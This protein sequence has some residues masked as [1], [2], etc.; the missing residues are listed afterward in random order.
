MVQYLPSV[1]STAADTDPSR[2]SSTCRR[3]LTRA[4]S[5]RRQVE[6]VRRTLARVVLAE[7][8]RTPLDEPDSARA[9]P[10]GSMREPDTDLGETLPQVAFFART[11]LP[12][13]LKDLMRS[14]GPALSYQPPGYG[15][16]LRR[17]QRLFRNRLDADRSV[18]QRSAK[19]ITR[20]LLTWAT[21]SVA[22][23]TAGHDWLQPECS[24]VIAENPFLT[25]EAEVVGCP[26]PS[27]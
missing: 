9:V 23:P 5:D 13:G 26:T 12:A 19:S 20:P 14:E 3:L 6:S 24:R 10:A 22:V 1:H 11:R 17:R 27:R 25:A 7:S 4:D 18:G 8:G 2:R 16:G 21:G 15:Q